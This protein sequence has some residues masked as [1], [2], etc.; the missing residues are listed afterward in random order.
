M[1][2]KIYIYDL[3]HYGGLGPRSK[4]GLGLFFL[5]KYVLNVKRIIK[6]VLKF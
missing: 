3:I 5:M 4:R 6:R 2:Y 1:R